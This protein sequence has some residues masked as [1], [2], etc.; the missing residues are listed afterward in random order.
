MRLFALF[1]ALLCLLS[2]ASAQTGGLSPAVK[3]LKPVGKITHLLITEGSGIIK[4]RRYPNTYWT[5]NDSGDTARIWP[6]RANGDV[7]V[8]PFLLKKV[9]LGTLGTTEKPL[10]GGLP[11][12]GASNYDWED[13]TLDGDTLYI[14]DMGN[15]NNA[16]QDLGVY[17]LTEP[18]PLSVTHA[19]AEKWLHIAYPDQRQF[20][21]IYP[22]GNWNYDCEALFVFHTKLYFLTKHRLMGRRNLP[23]MSTTLYRL[24]TQY[25]D[26]LNVLTKI[27]DKN[28]LGGWVT[29]AALSPSGRTLAVLCHLPIPSVWLFD[30][31]NGDRFLSGTARRLFLSGAGQ[32]EGICWDD[33]ANLRITNEEGDIFTVNTGE[34]RAVA[35]GNRVAPKRMPAAKKAMPK[36]KHT[37]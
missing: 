8:P 29:A 33:A 30:I 3:Q 22:T 12:D 9:S 15:N 37:P 20:P 21:P 24:D 1:V 17:L 2:P 16:R 7:I 28:D 5:L 13:I 4:S 32:C 25:T 26:R 36:P 31:P 18:N 19:R 34:F 14:S 27:E 10:W 6:I 35:N 23:A 11:I